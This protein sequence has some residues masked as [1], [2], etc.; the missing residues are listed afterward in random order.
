MHGFPTFFQIGPS[1][2]RK[3]TQGS[4]PIRSS[5]EHM[6]ERRVET[7]TLTGRLVVVGKSLVRCADALHKRQAAGNSSS[8]KS[9]LSRTA[10]QICALVREETSSLKTRHSLR[11]G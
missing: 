7:R 5:G 9:H 4:L 11:C 8:L 10:I 3:K 2:G 6:G 1:P